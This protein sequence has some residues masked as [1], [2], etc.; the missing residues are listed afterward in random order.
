MKFAN[1][2]QEVEW[3]RRAA[4]SK[5][6]FSK[7][8]RAPPRATRKGEQDFH[9]WRVNLAS[10]ASGRLYALVFARQK[11]NEDGEGEESRWEKER[12]GEGRVLLN[13]SQRNSQNVGGT[14]APNVPAQPA[15]FF[16]LFPYR[17][18]PSFA[19][20]L[21]IFTLPLPPHF[22]ATKILR[23]ALPPS[24]RC[25]HA[26]RDYSLTKQTERTKNKHSLGRK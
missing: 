21:F 24:W 16:P 20:S 18:C 6:S 10:G 2:L 13:A 19:V 4:S 15:I 26:F 25:I 23:P 1:I 8:E 9:S 17:S 22:R 14:A 7:V 12:S 5:G 3:R 11:G